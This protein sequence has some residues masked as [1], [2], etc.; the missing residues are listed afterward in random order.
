MMS[1][2]N[3]CLGERA[4]STGNKK[5]NNKDTAA[6]VANEF[7]FPYSSFAV[8]SLCMWMMNDGLEFTQPCELEILARRTRIAALFPNHSAMR[9][10]A[11]A[12]VLPR[13]Q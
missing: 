12:F 8:D 2:Q 4:T 3:R 6:R 1:I 9:R 10:S 13:I 11:C 7:R 5:E